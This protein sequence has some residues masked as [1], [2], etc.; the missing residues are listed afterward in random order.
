MHIVRGRPSTVEDDRS[1]T[2]RLT[3]LVA[4][5]GEPAIRA[6]TPTRQVAFG[7]RDATADGFVRAQKL[8]VERGYTPVQRG[9]G[10]HA[11]VYTGETVA[12]VFVT[13]DDGDRSGIQARYEHATE[14]LKRTLE[15]LG[16]QVSRGEPDAAYCPGDHSLQHAGKI[17]GL[18][19]RVRRDAA[20]VGGCV[21][22]RE[23]DEPVIGDVL[24][25][26]YD[27][28]GIEFD[29]T[30]VGSV[31]SAGGSGDPE[32]VTRSI[33]TTFLGDRTGTVVEAGDLLS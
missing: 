23:A 4:N 27:A 24:S 6:W 11:V 15:R 7:R 28:L 33:E 30:S 20:V 3:E 5:T 19:Q 1:I 32:Q 18:A 25:S 14:L 31:E 13:P 2:S 10:G 17:A 22:V 9:V 16:T 21:T 8:A 29:P 26:V 12:F